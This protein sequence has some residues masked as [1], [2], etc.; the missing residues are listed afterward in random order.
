MRL[1]PLIL[2]SLLV[3]LIYATSA[4]SSDDHDY[5]Y[6]QKLEKNKDPRVPEFLKE[7][8]QKGNPGNIK[9][10][11][12]VK[13]QKEKHSQVPELYLKNKKK[14]RQA[15]RISWKEKNAR[16]HF[17]EPS[18]AKGLEYGEGGRFRLSRTDCSQTGP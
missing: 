7:S 17:H 4:R 12:K 5:D 10:F 18:V 1:F 14:R 9:G 8:K 15:K 11:E 16:R 6:K 13:P 3:A 2:T